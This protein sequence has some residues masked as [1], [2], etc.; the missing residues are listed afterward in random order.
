MSLTKRHSKEVRWGHLHEIDYRT[1][2]G[3]KAWFDRHPLRIKHLSSWRNLH[4]LA[5][6][7][8]V[9]TMASRS[10]SSN[11]TLREKLELAQVLESIIAEEQTD[12]TIAKIV[13]A[14]G[15]DLK[16]VPKSLF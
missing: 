8:T 7:A 11:I 16:N 2:V 10:P 4:R 12:A 5:P 1:R 9:S 3:S 6:H 13:E 14:S 15:L